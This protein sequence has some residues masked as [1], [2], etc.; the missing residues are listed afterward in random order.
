MTIPSVFTSHTTAALLTTLLTTPG[1][2]VTLTPTT[3]TSSPFFD[4]LLVLVVSPLV[5]LTVVYALL[6]VRSRIRRRR[7]RA[8]KSLVERRL[9]KY[10]L[11]DH[12]TAS[13]AA[14][15]LVRDELLLD[16]NSR[17]NLATFCTT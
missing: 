15:N 6:L 17:Q 8:P 11:P 2:R 5:T 4:T 16:G 9:P 1:L 7:W 12:S 10:R 3:M 13:S 14:Y